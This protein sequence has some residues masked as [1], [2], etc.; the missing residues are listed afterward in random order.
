MKQFILF[1]TILLTY[2]VDCQA[3][4]HNRIY[5]KSYRTGVRPFT[6]PY[7]PGSNSIIIKNDTIV[8]P[9]NGKSTFLVY[10]VFYNSSASSQ[11]R[12]GLLVMGSGNNESNPT[13]G[14]L[15]EPAENALCNKAVQNGYVAAILQY[16][17]GPGIVNWNASAQQ[18]ADDYDVCISTL[19]TKFNIPKS[20]SVVGGVSYAG[21]LLLTVNAYFNTLNYCKGLL[22]PCSATNTDAASQF[23]IPIYN[24]CCKGEYEVGGGNVTGSTLYNAIHANVKSKS[25]CVIDNNCQSHCGNLWTNELYTKMNYWLQ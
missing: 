8:F 11:F 25:E 16:T 2:I 24:I 3:Q 7:N 21:F 9:R 17:K 14:K 5:Q 20:K 1:A 13:V 4:S 18:L 12:K 15:D 22:A 10:K 23:K 19:S 6:K